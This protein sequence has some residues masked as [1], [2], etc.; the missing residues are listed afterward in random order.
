MNMCNLTKMKDLELYQSVDVYI[1]LN[2]H[3][4]R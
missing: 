4:L 2:E 3:S 1:T